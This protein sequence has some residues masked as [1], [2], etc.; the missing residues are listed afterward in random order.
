MPFAATIQVKISSEA[1]EAV[2]LT[3]VV[4]TEMPIAEFMEQAP[5]AGREPVFV[6]DDLTDEY[7]FDVVNA[8]GG[9]SV[10]VG[11]GKSGARWQLDNAA[12][13]LAWLG[14]FVGRCGPEDAKTMAA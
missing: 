14:E 3:P 12:A 2:T 8:L 11:P 6:G 9:Y 4:V 5:F 1:A 13:V 10:K 7:G